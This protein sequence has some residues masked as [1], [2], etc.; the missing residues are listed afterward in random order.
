MPG[1]RQTIPD[2]RARKIEL[3]VRRATSE[4]PRK[5]AQV[6]GTKM[7]LETRTRAD[8]KIYQSLVERWFVNTGINDLENRREMPSNPTV[9]A[10][11][12]M[13][14]RATSESVAIK[15]SRP[16]GEKLVPGKSVV[17][18]RA[19]LIMSNNGW[20]ELGTRHLG[21]ALYDDRICDKIRQLRTWRHRTGVEDPWTE[22]VAQVLNMIA[23][24][25]KVPTEWALSKEGQEEGAAKARMK[26]LAMKKRERKTGK[27]QL[28]KPKDT[29]S[30]IPPTARAK[31]IVKTMI[32][33]AKSYS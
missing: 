20:S 33:K 30:P 26:Q 1:E 27:T 31:P 5:A 2:K 28:R 15:W 11:L 29:F 4:V 24:F 23:G 9:R 16:V 19:L 14:H 3:E 13:P 17:I 18:L 25:E 6:K 7:K 21:F 12:G 8:E 22:R 10:S 32:T